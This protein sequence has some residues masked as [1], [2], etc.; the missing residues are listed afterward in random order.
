MGRFKWKELGMEYRLAD[1]Q[2]PTVESVRDAC[3]RFQEAGL[4]AF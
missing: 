4:K 3:Q 1:V 2:P